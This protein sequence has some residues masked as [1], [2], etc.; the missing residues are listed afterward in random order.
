[1]DHPFA[2]LFISG[3]TLFAAPWRRRWSA[4][5]AKAASAASVPVSNR[6]QTPIRLLSRSSGRPAMRPRVCGPK[7][8]GNLRKA[9]RRCSTSLFALSTTESKETYPDWPGK[10]APAHRHYPDPIK[11]TGEWQR[12]CEF[13]RKRRRARGGSMILSAEARWFWRGEPPPGFEQWFVA[14]NV[15]AWEAK[16]SEPRRNLYLRSPDQQELSIKTV[17]SSSV[18]IKG[19][20]SRWLASVSVADLTAPLEIC[21]KRSPKSL[22]LSGMPLL[23]VDRRRWMQRFACGPAEM[24]PHKDDSKEWDAACDCEVEPSRLTAPD[25]IASPVGPALARTALMGAKSPPQVPMTA[26]ASYPS[27]RSSQGW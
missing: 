8:V 1:M 3:A 16:A 18:E 21:S 5:A 26:A 17:G 13:G 15:F 6:W 12:K 24:R 23:D 20:V 27:W 11:A 10:P 7:T 22:D 4:V 2:M 19:L 9:T 25:A 14:A